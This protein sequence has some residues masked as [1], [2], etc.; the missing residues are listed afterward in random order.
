MIEERLIRL[1]ELY[2]RSGF[3]IPSAIDLDWLKDKINSSDF[4]ELEN[5]FF[6]VISEYEKEFFIS[7]FKYSWGLFFEIS[8]NTPN[9]TN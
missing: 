8:E 6:Y 5:Q 7:C 1:F 3:Y 4:K 2:K 9:T